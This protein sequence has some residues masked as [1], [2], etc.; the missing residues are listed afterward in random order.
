MPTVNLLSFPNDIVQE[1]IHFCIPASVLS[2]LKYYNQ[3]IKYTQFGLMQLL[4]SKSKS[5][6]PSLEGVI[7][8]IKPQLENDYIFEYLGP[9]TYDE[10]K[11]NV[12]ENLTKSYPII[13]TTRNSNGPHVRVII[14]FDEP[15]N[16][17]SIFDPGESGSLDHL[18]N[19]TGNIIG[20]ILTIKSMIKTYTETEA[21]EDWENPNRCSDQLLIFPKN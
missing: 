14:G 13:F 18:L 16:T 19:Q 9:N 4:I 1:G 6:S 20:S 3:N 21:K 12:M 11:Y 10:W 8:A 5:N 7:E 2:V 17:F 15:T